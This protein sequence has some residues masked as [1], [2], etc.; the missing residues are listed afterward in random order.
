MQIIAHRGASACKPEN[1]L[2]AFKEAIR[3]GSLMYETDVQ[4]T[5]DGFLVLWHDYDFNGQNIKDIAFAGS[6]LT[7]LKDLIDILPV[8]SVLNMEIKNDGNIY[9]GIEA[10]IKTLLDACGPAA[11]EKFIISSFDYPT[12][13]RMRVLDARIK[14][15]VL[16][17]AFDILEAKNVNAYS[18]NISKR[19]V[20]KSVVEACRKEGIKI[21]VYTVNDAQTA[22][23]FEKMG[24]D[25]VFSDYPD[26]AF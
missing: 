7:L 3:L 15:A 19:R 25:A 5:K 18:V 17:R 10:Q 13:Q 23:R 24:V 21:M 16:T 6:N 9:P 2:E 20:N 11:K 26:L 22:R 1:T 8:K 12:L 14:I 4:R